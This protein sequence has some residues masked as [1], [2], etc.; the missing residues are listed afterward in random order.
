[1][2]LPTPPAA[3]VAV[4]EMHPDPF[5]QAAI[6]RVYA[7]AP[8]LLDAD[9]FLKIALASGLAP[10]EALVARQEAMDARRQ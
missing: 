4:Q 8:G 5:T 6:L 10:A 9:T 2:I 1:M 3:V 7:E